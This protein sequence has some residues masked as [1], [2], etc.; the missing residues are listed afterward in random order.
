MPS[1]HTGDLSGS[2]QFEALINA[3]LESLAPLTSYPARYDD[4][5]SR[6]RALDAT[7][8]SRAARDRGLDVVKL[9]DYTQTIT[10]GSVK[11]GFYQNMSWSL[12]TLDRIITHDKE[13]T[14][15]VLRNNSIP[16]ARGK[17]VNDVEE[18]I[19]F[20]HQ[21]D[22]SV[23]LKPVTGSGGKGITVDV[24]SEAELRQAFEDALARKPRIMVEESI[25]SIDLR[26]MVVTG[27]AIAAMMRVPAN[28]V[29]DGVSTISEL[30]ENKNLL[31]ERNPYLAHTPLTLD[32]AAL[33]RLAERGL[34][35]ESILEA[36]RR[37]FLHY[38][39]NLS[40]GGDSVDVT[41]RV[42]PEI[43]RLAERAASCFH[44][45][46]HAGVDILAQRL[47]TSPQ[48]QRCVVCEINCNNDMPMHEFPLF[49]GSIDASGLELEGYLT[50]L[51][52]SSS[53]LISPRTELHQQSIWPRVLRRLE[54]LKPTTMPESSKLNQMLSEGYK[55]TQKIS[56]SSPRNIDRNAMRREF[57]RRGY[58]S[59]TFSNRLVHAFKSNQEIVLERSARP[60]FA[61]KVAARRPAL[62]NLLASGGVPY[63]RQKT[64]RSDDLS[65]A[66][67][68]F[69]NFPGPWDV[70]AAAGAVSVRGSFAIT[71]VTSLERAWR[72]IT[73][74]SRYV[75]LRQASEG[76]AWKLLVVDGSISGCIALCQPAVV[77]DGTSTIAQ[78]V[79]Q[80]RK[81]RALHPYLKHY[82]GAEP[83]PS[84]RY[85][86]DR[87]LNQE[88]VLPAGKV[89]RLSKSTAVSDGADPVGYAGRADKTLVDHTAVL[90]DLLNH[91]PIVA[92][93]FARRSSKGTAHWAAAE[94]DVDP[95][96]AEFAFPAAGSPSPV[97]PKV[98]QL[99][100]RQ[101]QYVLPV[102][103]SEEASGRS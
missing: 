46:G 26:I 4:S 97:Y 28:I 82:A 80:R 64:F 66:V 79:E 2:L 102:E 63:C 87:G 76:H 11:I 59:V 77:G 73:R 99:L 25:P 12:T 33:Q 3:A 84:D 43:M 30:V 15:R 58:E 61:A 48:S 32:R 7:L 101:R 6:R 8:L 81:Q 91:P 42:H 70:R 29:G 34:T 67:A 52:T 89:L 69:E 74:R 68:W 53:H 45:V 90:L 38:K 37:I 20:F 41:A 23:V 13:L 47:D 16:V 57:K 31:R 44:S 50:H 92:F 83:K 88:T 100:L 54:R 9:D 85:L 27:H 75:T 22:G 60:V 55:A 5:A 65:S 93:T 21:L 14:K 94:V 40:S 19:D 62:E 18:A 103:A 56:G 36:G 96:L 72:R 95:V 39:A 35:P 24:R 51:R 98:A 17:E 71:R 49:G 86:A 1:L 10:D 78:L